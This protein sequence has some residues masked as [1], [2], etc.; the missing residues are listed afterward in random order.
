MDMRKPIGSAFLFSVL[1]MVLAINGCALASIPEATLTPV[2]LTDTPSPTHPTF[3]PE[4]NTTFT[5]TP[6]PVCI[7]GA[8]V[9]GVI[10]DYITIGFLDITKVTTSLEGTTLTLVMTLREIPSEFTVN[11][12][13]LP[14]GEPEITL[15]VAID[16]DG[17][18]TEF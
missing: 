14:E 13:E 3:T 1:V 10:N 17:D 15:G 16:V 9:E 2:P 5:P 12:K 4:S 11:P 18:P 7:P 6:A 8:T